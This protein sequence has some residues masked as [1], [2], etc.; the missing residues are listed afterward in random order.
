MSEIKFAIKQQ[1]CEIEKS[2]MVI[3]QPHKRKDFKRIT[4]K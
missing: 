1:S 3:C 2:K 4:R